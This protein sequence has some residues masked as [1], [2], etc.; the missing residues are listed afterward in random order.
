MEHN[1]PLVSIVTPVYRSEEILA[2]A[3][4]SLLGQDFRD[5]EAILVDD[6]SPE[7]SWRVVQAYGWIDPRIHVMRQPHAGACVARNTGISEAR[8]KYLLFLDADDWLE[9]DAL[10]SFLTACEKENW[11]AAYGGLRYVT[12]EGDP[13]QWEGGFTG[14][15]DLFDAIAG[16]NVLSVPSSTILRRSVLSDIGLFD[17]ALAHCGDWDLWAR[18]ARHD[19]PVGRVEKSVTSYRMRPGSLSR[20]PRTLLRDAM[21]TLRRIHAPDPRV[22]RPKPAFARGADRQQLGSRTCH[23]TVYAAGLATCGGGYEA[24]E[25]VL[26]M[27]TSWTRLTPQRAG[28]FLYYA[29]C[30]AHCCG[31]EGAVRF[32]PQVHESVG[33]LLADLE[34][35]TSTPGL[36]QNIMAVMD[37]CGEG[38][39]STLPLPLPELTLFGGSDPFLHSFDTVAHETLRSLARQQCA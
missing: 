31:P 8:G 28:E 24:A 32:W 6:G 5:W 39:V 38:P 16:S 1:R 2:K 13:T 35:R 20:N 17:S 36:A 23:F 15:V 37:A 27:V 3:I 26:D 21:T 4:G 19:G 22:R 12:P 18:L 29:L 9:P 30:F 34:R 33:R 11:D 25:Q 10:S 14:E 7:K